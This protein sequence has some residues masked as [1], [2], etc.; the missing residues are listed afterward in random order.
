MLFYILAV[1]MLAADQL[2]KA[3]VRSNLDIEETTQ[4]AGVHMIHYNNT[5]ASGSF[6]QGYG[7][8][9]VP[10]AVV[11]LA[12]VLYSRYRGKLRSVP[13]EIGTGLFVAGAVGNAIDRLLYGGVTDFI[14]FREGIVAN[15]ADLCLNVGMIVILVAMFFGRKKAGQPAK[16][17]P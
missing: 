9:F 15:I 4:V 12:V 2:T 11:V 10:V 3:W 8:W 13:M 1:V 7:Q 16:H 14:Q 6:F 17:F 5:G